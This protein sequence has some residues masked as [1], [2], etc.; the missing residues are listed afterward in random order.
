MDPIAQ[1]D[2]L[3]LLTSRVHAG[4]PSPAADHADRTLSLYRRFVPRPSSMFV[5]G[6]EGDSMLGVQVA[7]GDYLIIDKSRDPRDG[8]VVVAEIDGD[9]IRRLGCAATV[10]SWIRN[11]LSWVRRRRDSKEFGCD[12]FLRSTGFEVTDICAVRIL[13]DICPERVVLF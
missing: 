5:M 1:P 11:V 8:D 2:S 10:D 13:S 6:V 12:G 3:P 7:N 9:L 4:F